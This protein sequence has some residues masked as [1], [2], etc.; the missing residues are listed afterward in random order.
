MRLTRLNC[1]ITLVLI[2]K[3]VTCN[4]GPLPFTW[5]FTLNTRKSHGLST[6]FGVGCFDEFQTFMCVYSY[7]NYCYTYFGTLVN[8]WLLLTDFGNIKGLR[9]V[10]HEDYG[11]SNRVCDEEYILQRLYRLY[12]LI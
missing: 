12:H 5:Y 11:C 7:L 9:V 3:K 1:R 2:I 8:K 4:T 6:L 10:L